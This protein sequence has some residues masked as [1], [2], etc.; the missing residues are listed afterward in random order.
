MRL[1]GAVLVGTPHGH[2]S[3]AVGD[4]IL[5]LKLGNFGQPVLSPAIYVAPY[6]CLTSSD[7]LFK[8]NPVQL[9]LPEKLE[10]KTCRPRFVKRCD[11]SLGPR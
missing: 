3:D 6:V 9:S 11:K 2:Q 7:I 4:L 1:L 10:P 8:E 5:R